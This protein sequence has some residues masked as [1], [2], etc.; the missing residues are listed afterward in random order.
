M[1]VTDSAKPEELATSMKALDGLPITYK[2]GGHDAADFLSADLIVINPAVD[3]AK[4]GLVQAALK[5]GCFNH[6]G[7]EALTQNT[8]PPKSSASLASVGKSA[9]DG[10]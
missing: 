2:L 7:N 4:S 1:T 10:I 5:K 8:A 9:S 3:R 6:H